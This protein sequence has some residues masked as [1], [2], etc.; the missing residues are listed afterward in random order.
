MV[1][2][3]GKFGKIL[4]FDLLIEIKGSLS[5]E[6][7][8]FVSHTT[9]FLVMQVKHEKRLFW[10]FSDPHREGGIGVKFKRSFTENSTQDRIE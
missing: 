9:G 1:I 7:S 8:E 10:Y 4:C 2:W 3:S 5:E 6:C